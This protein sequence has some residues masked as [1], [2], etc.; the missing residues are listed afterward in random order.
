MG[1]IVKLVVG[2]F[3]SILGVM[4]KHPVE[5][6]DEVKDVGREQPE[7]PDDAFTSGDW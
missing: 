5:E 2:L 1:W 4:M 7:N 6:K 3:T